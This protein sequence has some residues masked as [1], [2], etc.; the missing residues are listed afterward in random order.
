MNQGKWGIL[1]DKKE[2]AAVKG[3]KKKHKKRICPKR[4]AKAKRLGYYPLVHLNTTSVNWIRDLCEDWVIP[5]M[6]KRLKD[7]SKAYAPWA[8]RFA[9]VMNT[10]GKASCEDAKALYDL[11]ID[12]PYWEQSQF[13]AKN[14][15]KTMEEIRRRRES[16]SKPEPSKGKPI[17]P[18]QAT[19]SSLESSSAM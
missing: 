6:G 18:S 8:I 13:L 12:S 3:P 15:N 11:V 1:M 9:V 14:Y 7:P 17:S 5:M 16:E 19:A 4:T 10:L 2:P